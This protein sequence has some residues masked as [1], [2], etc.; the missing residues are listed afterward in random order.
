M[1]CK[2]SKIGEVEVVSYVANYNSYEILKELERFLPIWMKNHKI[3]FI[4]YNRDK[5]ERF[6]SYY[7]ENK[8]KNY[9]SCLKVDV[10]RFKKSFYEMIGELFSD[11]FSYNKKSDFSEIYIDI[12]HVVKNPYLYQFHNKK[13]RTKN[14]RRI[15]AIMTY[16]IYKEIVYSKYN[17]TNVVL[18]RKFKTISTNEYIDRYM[19]NKFALD[20]YEYIYGEDF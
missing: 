13:N 16:A 12:R 10:S 14:I 15:C 7:V 19:S 17:V 8:F 9:F 5:D 11:G 18:T 4:I 6:N 2:A 1:S 20:R 3:K